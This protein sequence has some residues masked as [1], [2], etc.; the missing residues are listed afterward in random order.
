MAFLAADAFYGYFMIHCLFSARDGHDA[1]LLE[2]FYFNRMLEGQYN[3]TLGKVIGFT[4]KGK[5]MADILNK[6]PR[7]LEHELWKTNFCKKSAQPFYDGH[8]NAVEPSV[9]LRSVEEAGSKHPAVLVC[10]AYMFYPKQIKVT[11]LRNGKK[12]T[13]DV[14]ST[15]VLSNGNW[16]YQIH[17]YLEFTPRLGEKIT[18]MVEHASF[19]EPKL[20]EWELL[21]ESALIKIIAGASGLLLGLIFAVAGLIYYKMKSSALIQVPTTEVLYP[22][23]TL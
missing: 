5:E 7:F 12:I 4:K 9:R 14:M 18:C 11:W 6:S 17:S 1:V 19:R 16:L 21:S 22:D 23:N 8:L 20:Y 3:S 13:D 15:E 10:S 2:Q